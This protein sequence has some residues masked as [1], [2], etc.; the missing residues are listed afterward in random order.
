MQKNPE[1]FL[2]PKHPAPVGRLKLEV[3]D[4]KNSGVDASINGTLATLCGPATL[5]CFA[6]E[7]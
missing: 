5:G 7:E 4:L 1:N 3:V 6:D 2:N